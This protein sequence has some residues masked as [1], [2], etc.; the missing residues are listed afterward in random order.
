MTFL[1]IETPV[2]EH[3]PVDMIEQM[4]DLNEW[5]FERIGDD[6]IAISVAGSWTD[7]QLSFT[8][9]D[10]LEALHLA[11]VF[12]LKTPQ[13]RRAEMARLLA[14]V[15]EQLWL[16]H[17]DLWADEGAILYRHGV[18]LSDGA[19]LNPAQCEA[20]IKAATEACERYYQAFQFVVWAGKTAEEALETVLFET[21]GEA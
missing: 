8:W 14:L 2:K 18:L 15:N 9:R 1:D 17:F 10:D 20:L 4:A 7:Y 5:A 3:N 21:L 6:E 12:D 13:R 11:C 16:G 19:T